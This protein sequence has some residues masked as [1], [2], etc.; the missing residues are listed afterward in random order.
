MADVLV[1]FA[2]VGLG[3]LAA[4]AAVIGISTGAR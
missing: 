3:A 4:L 2:A 1:A